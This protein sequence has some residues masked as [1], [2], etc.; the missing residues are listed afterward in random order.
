MFRSQAH[1]A[2]FGCPLVRL[3]L[4]HATAQDYRPC[5]VNSTRA[6]SG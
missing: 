1:A 3:C 5:T 2:A 6:A 4:P